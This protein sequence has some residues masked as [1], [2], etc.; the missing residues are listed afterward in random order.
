ML[1]PFRTLHGPPDLCLKLPRNGGH[2]RRGLSGMSRA[3][4]LTY[5]HTGAPTLGDP[6]RVVSKGGHI[7]PNQSGQHSTGQARTMQAQHRA[8]THYAGTAQHGHT[9]QATATATAQPHS[10]RRDSL[11]K[12]SQGICQVL[13]LNKIKTCN[14]HAFLQ[15]RLLRAVVYVF[16]T[17]LRGLL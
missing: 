15:T 13:V 7:R 14:S 16:F 10:I 12:Q 6:R 5:D 2:S 17:N 11:R 4:S 9:A 1:P 8:S 3:K